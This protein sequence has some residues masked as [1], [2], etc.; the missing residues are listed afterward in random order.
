[1]PTLVI[2]NMHEFNLDLFMCSYAEFDEGTESF[3]F[4]HFTRVTLWQ[5]HITS[6]AAARSSALW[7][8][9]IHQEPLLL[10]C[11]V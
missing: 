1:M 2:T 11:Q 9:S 10:L 6:A 3:L 8:H 5:H 7:G 4:Y